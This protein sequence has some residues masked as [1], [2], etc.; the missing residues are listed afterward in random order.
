M[1]IIAPKHVRLFM[2]Y[3][4]MLCMYF[5]GLITA[6]KLYIFSKKINGK[7]QIDEGMYI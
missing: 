3:T 5:V 2:Y 4:I 1:V 6:Y 7:L